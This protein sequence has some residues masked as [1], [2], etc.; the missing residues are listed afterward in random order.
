MARSVVVKK[1]EKINK[2]FEQI[3]IDGTYEEFAE[4]FKEDYSKDWDRINK[5]YNQHEKKDVKGKGHPMPNPN[6]YM[7]N[8]Y[9]VGREKHSK[10]KLNLTDER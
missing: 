6:Q 3:G 8:M 7:K 1:E 9:N 2:I 5:V 10:L 4:K